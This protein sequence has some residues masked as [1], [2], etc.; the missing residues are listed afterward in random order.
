MGS[1]ISVAIAELM[2]QCFESK[3]LLNRQCEPLFWKRYVDDIIA[4]IPTTEL[5]NFTQ[6][7]NSQNDNIKITAKI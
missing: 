7:L 2:M 4:A 5:G 1:P 6:H 3:A